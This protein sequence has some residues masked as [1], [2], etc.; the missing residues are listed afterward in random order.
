[1]NKDVCKKFQDVEEW[2]IGELDSNG[3][4]Q[5]IQDEDFQKYCINE[6]DSNL[7]KINAVCLYLLDQFYK[8]DGMFP[9]PSNS[10]PN[11]VDNIFIW[12]SY[13]LNLKETNKNE[14]N[15]LLKICK[16]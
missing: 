5:F 16:G 10:N 7:D 6:C 11:I 14:G 3:E 4:N 1:M 13:M 2:F 8:H 15:K 9:S 12:L